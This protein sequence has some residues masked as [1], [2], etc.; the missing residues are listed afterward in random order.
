MKDLYGELKKRNGQK[1][2]TLTQNKPAT[3][4]VDDHKVTIVYPSGNSLEI[5]RSMVMEAIH[6]LQSKGCLTL[7][8][9][10]YTITNEF[11]PQTDR[12]LAVL[13]ELPGVTF[14]AA[15]RALYF[16]ANSINR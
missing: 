2:F 9:V 5:P 7:E 10:H 12:L 3:M 13:R 11:G 14:T 8:D 15:P 16:D 1:C 6:K 4:Y